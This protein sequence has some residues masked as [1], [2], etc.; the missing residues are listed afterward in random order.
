MIPG[1]VLHNIKL[2]PDML[3]STRLY[4]GPDGSPAA[5]NFNLSKI[6]EMLKQPREI[7]R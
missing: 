5:W 2:G 6:Y 1:Y 7:Y 4:L 3:R